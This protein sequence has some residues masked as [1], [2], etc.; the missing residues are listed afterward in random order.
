M[1]H[2]RQGLLFFISGLDDVRRALPMPAAVEAMREAFRDLAKGTVVMP[3]RTR[4]ANP[5]GDEVSLVMPSRSDG[6]CPPRRQAHHALRPQSGRGAAP[7]PCLF[8]L[9]DSGTGVP[10]AIL[11]GGALT[12]LR[13]GA[14]SGLATDVLARPD[15]AVAA[16]FGAG[17][18]ARSQLDAVAAVR[19]LREAR[20]YD[21]VAAA[22]ESFAVEMSARLNVPVHPAS[23]PAAALRGADIVCTATNSRSPLFADGDLALGTHINAVG[24]YQLER[25]EIP[26]ATVRRARIVVDQTEAAS[27]RRAILS[28]RSRRDDRSRPSGLD[29]G[30]HPARPRRRPSLARRDHPLQIRRLGRP[31]PLRRRPC[32][33]EC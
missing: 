4:M 18:Q 5:A 15:A 30:R 2:P 26:A 31:G 32:I 12:A 8:V 33:R 11:D 22:A 10:L 7:G 9:A 24:V 21:P 28:S 13:T 14:I 1:T 17:V 27:R 23:D 3:A 25:A 20:V 19:P 16:I 29:L 6:I